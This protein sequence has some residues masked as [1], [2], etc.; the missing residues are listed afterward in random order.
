M[1]T[2][3]AAREEPTT[4]RVCDDT[5]PSLTV[6]FAEALP[7]TVGLKVTTTW[8]VAAGARGAPV[9]VDEEENWEAPPTPAFV[10]VSAPDGSPP[11]LVTVKL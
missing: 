6:K 7:A 2:P 1:V 5:V 4:F 10:T 9:Q 8:Q 3:G 11:L